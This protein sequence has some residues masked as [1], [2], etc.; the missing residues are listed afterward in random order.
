MAS[1][2]VFNRSAVPLLDD[3]KPVEYRCIASD[4]A[5]RLLTFVEQLATQFGT[6]SHPAFLKRA[7]KLAQTLP[8]EVNIIAV[9]RI[10]VTA[11]S[12][13]VV[14][15]FI[16]SASVLHQRIGLVQSPKARLP[17]TSSCS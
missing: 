11:C 17:G 10:R 3:D 8:S 6:V 9:P 12:C 2:A 13:Y 1:S 15:M 4:V 7:A 14:W 16:K 5:T